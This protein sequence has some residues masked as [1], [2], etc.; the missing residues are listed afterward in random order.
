MGANSQPISSRPS[1]SGQ[2]EILEN[3][4]SDEGKQNRG[5]GSSLGEEL[6]FFP[7]FDGT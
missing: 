1:A 5:G 3:E 4:S 6:K 7:D 2:Q